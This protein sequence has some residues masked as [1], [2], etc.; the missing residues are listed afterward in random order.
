MAITSVNYFPLHAPVYQALGLGHSF[1]REITD[2]IAEYAKQIAMVDLS[3]RA[4]LKR[5]VS[6]DLQNDREGIR[7]LHALVT[8]NNIV[9]PALSNMGFIFPINDEILEFAMRFLSHGGTAVEQGGGSSRNALIMACSGADKVYAN[10]LEK[11]EMGRYL[12]MLTKLPKPMQKK[13]RFIL[14]NFLEMLKTVPDLRKNVRLVLNRNV[15][16]FL[17]DKDLA[18]AVQQ[19]HEILEPGGIAIITANS[20][21]ALPEQKDKFAQNPDHTSFASWTVNMAD[22]STSSEPLRLAVQCEPCKGS[23]VATNPARFTLSETHG[24]RWASNQAIPPEAFPMMKTPFPNIE[25]LIDQ[26]QKTYAHSRRGEIFF[27][28]TI[29]RFFTEENL[30]SIFTKSGFQLLTSFKIGADHH[31]FVETESD[32]Y[33][34]VGQVGVIVQKPMSQ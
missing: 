17:N 29:M 28:Q 3:D 33:G 27:N 20:I 14:G 22:Y 2:I 13:I 7:K 30:A 11:K 12:S 31:L 16:H 26:A 15:Y 25:E 1:P 9:E 21:Y 32:P 24:F 8:Q 5:L 6:K 10:D 34:K 19:L 4:T 18:A 23:Q